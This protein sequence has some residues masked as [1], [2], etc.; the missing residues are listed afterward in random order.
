MVE[1]GKSYFTAWIYGK[2][3]H[4]S[5]KKQAKKIVQEKTN[6]LSAQLKMHNAQKRKSPC[7]PV[8][9]AARLITNLK[10]HL[11][12]IM[13]IF[14]T[15]FPR[16][17]AW[18]ALILTGHSSTSELPSPP[19]DSTHNS[20]CP[21]VPPT[22][23]F[24]FS[25]SA[26]PFSITD[27][28]PPPCQNN[29]CSALLQLSLLL[30]QRLEPEPIKKKHWGKHTHTHTHILAKIW[31]HLITP[32]CGCEAISA[33]VTSAAKEWVKMLWKSPGENLRKDFFFNLWYPRQL[34]HNFLKELFFT[35]WWRVWWEDW[36]HSHIC[37]ANIKL[38]PGDG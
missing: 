25:F 21:L 11:E 29:V 20:V 17:I 4:R 22:T 2:S 14:R 13:C 18:N 12:T 15:T 9:L 24:F 1:I 7:T 37:S 5:I 26:G 31:V 38:E 27:P 33:T 3:L 10:G 19:P 36:F 16:T 35:F 32:R 23:S 30:D 34:C 28:P 6:T 8:R